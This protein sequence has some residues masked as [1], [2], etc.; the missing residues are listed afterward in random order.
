MTNVID[1]IIMEF[2]LAYGK[3]ELLSNNFPLCPIST[4]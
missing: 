3:R 2:K 4:C 1:M